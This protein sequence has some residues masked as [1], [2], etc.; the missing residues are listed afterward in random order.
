MTR[1]RLG[2]HGRL[3]LESRLFDSFEEMFEFIKRERPLNQ[4]R[5]TALRYAPG[6]YLAN[7]WEPKQAWKVFPSRVRS[8]CDL[9][10]PKLK[11]E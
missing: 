8:V 5:I 6:V 9:R 4:S 1:L 2:Y 11:A 10:K 7:D 3:Q